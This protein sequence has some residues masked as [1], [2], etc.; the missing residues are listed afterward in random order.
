MDVIWNTYSPVMRISIYVGGKHSHESGEA[1]NSQN[2]KQRFPKW[3]KK[4]HYLA[5]LDSKLFSFNK[6]MY[7]C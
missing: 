5:H 4:V 1:S 3:T 2:R 7:F 6:E